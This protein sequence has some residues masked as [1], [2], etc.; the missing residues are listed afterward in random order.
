MILSFGKVTNCLIFK[1]TRKNIIEKNNHQKRLTN[2]I[3]YFTFSQTKN[4]KV[5]QLIVKELYDKHSLMQF[6]KKLKGIISCSH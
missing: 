4:G 3:T 1:Q 5:K 2:K 6:T